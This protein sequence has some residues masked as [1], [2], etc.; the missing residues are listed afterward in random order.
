MRPESYERGCWE[1]LQKEY[2]E[3]KKEFDEAARKLEKVRREKEDFLTNIW[4]EN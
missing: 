1:S 4:F 3:A 2:N